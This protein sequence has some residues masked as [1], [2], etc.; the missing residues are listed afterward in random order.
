MMTIKNSPQW[1][2]KQ[3]KSVGSVTSPEYRV[4]SEV[5]T[6]TIKT[7]AQWTQ[8]REFLFGGLTALWRSKVLSL[9][10]KQSPKWLILSSLPNNTEDS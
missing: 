5:Q 6:N 2:C 7:I 1:N 9:C 3:Q 8:E 10:V 4:F